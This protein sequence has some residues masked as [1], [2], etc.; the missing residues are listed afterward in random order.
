[1]LLKRL[2]EL[3]EQ[4]LSTSD[5]YNE[6]YKSIELTLTLSLESNYVSL[7]IYWCDFN[8]SRRERYDTQDY[9]MPSRLSLGASKSSDSAT[10]ESESEDDDDEMKRSRA[11]QAVLDFGQLVMNVSVS[12]PMS[13]EEIEMNEIINKIL[14][15]DLNRVRLINPLV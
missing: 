13:R 9:S 5:I 14:E 15:Y 6:F 7:Y 10:S 1:M 8:N 12:T 2:N 11:R 3:K 4:K